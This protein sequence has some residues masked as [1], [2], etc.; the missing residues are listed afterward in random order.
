MQ[1][2]FGGFVGRIFDTIQGIYLSP[3][4]SRLRWSDGGRKDRNKRRRFGV[5]RV[6]GRLN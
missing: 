2:E 1:I 5:F 4:D 3:L 6:D